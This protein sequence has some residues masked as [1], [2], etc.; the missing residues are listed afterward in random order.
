M[1][2]A[3]TRG[4]SRCVLTD[5]KRR[6]ASRRK[7]TVMGVGGK[8]VSEESGEHLLLHL[9]MISPVGRGERTWKEATRSVKGLSTEKKRRSM[10]GLGKNLLSPEVQGRTK[11]KKRW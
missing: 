3:E 9:R 2:E 5:E 10:L 4:E 1:Q 8:K 11:E 6:G 7:T